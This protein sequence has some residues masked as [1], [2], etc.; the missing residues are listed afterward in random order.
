LSK[1]TK[2]IE[3]RPLFEFANVIDNRHL[4]AASVGPNL[5]PLLLTLDEKPDYRIETSPDQPSFPKKRAGRPNRFRIHHQVADEV[6]TTLDLPETDENYHAVQPLGEEKWLLVR[7]R[8]DG[9]GDRNAHV[10]DI[11]GRHVRSFPAEDGIQ[12]VQVT[13]GGD[14]WVSYFDEGL[15]GGTRLGHAGLAR[16]DESGNCSFEFNSTAVGVP[17]IVDCYALNVASDHDVLLYYYTDFPLVR[18][19]DGKVDRV[20]SKVPVKGSSAFAVRADMVLFVGGYEKHNELVLARFGDRRG[21]TLAVTDDGG[22]PLGRFSAFGRR[23]RLFLQTE[24]ALHLVEVPERLPG[25]RPD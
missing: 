9:D 21:T 15:F 10:H 18:L 20:W 13:R 6:W 16:L 17:D 19:L 8:A 3:A 23:D 1:R 5:D 2:T 4:V 7:G 11:K 25:V 14:I 24:D 12:D 22:R